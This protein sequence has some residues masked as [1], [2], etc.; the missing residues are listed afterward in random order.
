MI[1]KNKN[2]QES[3]LSDLQKTEQINNEANKQLKLEEVRLNELREEKIRTE[4]VIATHRET[5]KQIKYLEGF[6]KSINKKLSNKSFV[7][8]APK[9]IVDTE[10][11]KRKDATIKLEKFDTI[12]RYYD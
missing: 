3:I 11:K 8:N 6:L 2:D 9:V 1:K 7:D 4:G 5:L 10:N 12:P